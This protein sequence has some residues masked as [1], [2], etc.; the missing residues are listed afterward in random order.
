MEKTLKLWPHGLGALQTKNEFVEGFR[1]PLCCNEAR[2][3]ALEMADTEKGRG[4]SL[5]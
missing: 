1:N 2:I 4:G 5:L 3:T